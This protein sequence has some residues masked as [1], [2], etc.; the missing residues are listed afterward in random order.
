MGPIQQV[1][2]AFHRAIAKEC[3]KRLSNDLQGDAETP[4]QQL[5]CAKA[6]A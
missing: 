6:L 5:A 1:P 3:N 4:D 2:R